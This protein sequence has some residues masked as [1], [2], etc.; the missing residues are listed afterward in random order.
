MI[1]DT[2]CYR[3]TVGRLEQMVSLVE[4]VLTKTVT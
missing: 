3:L 4:G 1:K 2:D